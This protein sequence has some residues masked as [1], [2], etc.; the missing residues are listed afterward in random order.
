M[1]VADQS[2][3]LYD[4][5]WAVCHLFQNNNLIR[6]RDLLRKTDHMPAQGFKPKSIFHQA[7]EPLKALAQIGRPNG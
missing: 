5:S 4:K 2:V 1:S 7:E 6:L 3:P